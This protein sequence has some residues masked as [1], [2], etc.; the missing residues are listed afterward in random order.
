MAITFDSPY[1]LKPDAVKVEINQFGISKGKIIARLEYVD[2]SAGIIEV[3]HIDFD[4]ADYTEIMNQTIKTSHVG[5]KLSQAL[6]RLIQTK[7]KQKKGFTGT[8]D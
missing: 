6:R 8:E 7:V 1:K 2:S 3:E 5:M 4:G